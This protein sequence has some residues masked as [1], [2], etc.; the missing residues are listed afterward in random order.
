MQKS[1]A[2][3]IIMMIKNIVG[4]PEQ[5]LVMREKCFLIYAQAEQ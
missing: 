2:I 3:S 1:A 4:R 5:F